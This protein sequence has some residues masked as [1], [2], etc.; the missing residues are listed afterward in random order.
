MPK[1]NLRDVLRLAMK[2]PP[3]MEG[4]IT[5]KTTIH[6]PPLSGKVK[7]KLLLDGQFEVFQGKFLRSTI[8]NQ[9]DNLSRRGQGQPKNEEI[10]EV[11]S[12]LGG[13]F[14]LENEVITFPALSFTVEGAAI[15]LAGN[16]DLDDDVLDFHGALQLEAKVSQTMT[17]WK[18]WILKPLD[19]F[20]SKNG[21]GTVLRIKVEGS[22]KKPQFG[23][24]RGRKDPD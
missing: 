22:S 5:L 18:R 19:P 11:I 13:T 1:G 21:S 10:D 3:L 6:I 4:Q 8:Q 14:K 15:D 20:F 16:Y 7:E 17:G 23:L 9:I 12:M 2:G 24:A